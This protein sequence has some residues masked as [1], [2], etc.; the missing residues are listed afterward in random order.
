M[1][2]M[3][4]RPRVRRLA[5]AGAEPVAR[6]L[7][8]LGLGPNAVSVLGAAGV[9]LAALA[10]LPFGRFGWGLLLIAL[11]SAGDLLDGTMARLSGRT[12]RWGAFLDSVVDRIS[13][14]AVLGGIALYF[15]RTDQSLLAGLAVAALLMGQ[16][17][18]YTK[19]RAE[20]LGAT[21]DVGVA[22]RAERVLIVLLAL[23][24]AALGIDWALPLALA[25]LTVL[26]M[27]TIGQRIIVVRRQLHSP[28]GLPER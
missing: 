28:S 10:T 11:L 25:L 20:S 6:A 18:S 8:Q 19:A 15:A 27:V 9:S 14:G 3:L 24:G 1:A 4:N 16:V 22:E 2:V 21:A 12:S 7:L 26:G 17:T 13:D 23:L 5:A